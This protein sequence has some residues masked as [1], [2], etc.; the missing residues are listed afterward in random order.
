MATK[1]AKLTHLREFVDQADFDSPGEY[2]TLYR[3]L[4]HRFW[5]QTG[6]ETLVLALVSMESVKLGGGISGR[7]LVIQKAKLVP[8]K[9]E[10]V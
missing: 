9:V 8:A 2:G 3:I 7:R 5:S 1:K 4:Q 6:G 10:A